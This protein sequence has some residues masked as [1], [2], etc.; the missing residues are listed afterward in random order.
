MEELLTLAQK[1]GAI[2][3]SVLVPLVSGVIIP[4]I[5][6]RQGP[7]DPAAVRTLKQHAKLHEALPESS[8]EPIER[9]IA[10]E[11]DQYA[12]GIMRKG[13]GR[14]SWFNLGILLVLSLV[15]GLVVYGLFMLT[16]LWWPA[17]ILTAVVGG[18]G[19]ALVLGAAANLFTY[20]DEDLEHASP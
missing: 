13:T 2:I 15:V 10:F 9:L 19:G 11:A 14:F 20:D 12:R 4:L 8:R 7:K 6:Q 3:A 17:F 1:Y 5:S 18:I 16:V